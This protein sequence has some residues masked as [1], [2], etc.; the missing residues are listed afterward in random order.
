M[1]KVKWTIDSLKENQMLGL[2][3]TKPN[4]IRIKI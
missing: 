1:Y 3:K 2:F 4:K